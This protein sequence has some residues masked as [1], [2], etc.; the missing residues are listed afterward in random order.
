[1]SDRKVSIRNQVTVQAVIRLSEIEIRA[2]DA[3]AG[4]GIDAFLQVFYKQLGKCYMEPHEE[5]LRK[6]FE[7]I[8]KE[9]RPAMSIIDEARTLLERV[10]Q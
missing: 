3:L 8:E 9:C 5:G 7:N 4:Y 10:K 1:M 6:L 2:L